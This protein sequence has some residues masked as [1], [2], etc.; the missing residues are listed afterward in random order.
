MTDVFRLHWSGR[1]H[2][3]KVSRH[4]NAFFSLAATCKFHDPHRV[5]FL[6]PGWTDQICRTYLVVEEA[7]SHFRKAGDWSAWSQKL[8]DDFA[9]C[10]ISKRPRPGND[11]WDIPGAYVSCERGAKMSA[12]QATGFC[13]P[14]EWRFG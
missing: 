8:C 5:A 4:W 14:D 1:F 12:H 9:D 3:I 7:R 11:F 10:F 2:T 13:G 6:E